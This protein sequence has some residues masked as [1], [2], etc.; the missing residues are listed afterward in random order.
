MQTG[1]RKTLTF[2]SVVKTMWP[3]SSGF[4]C[5]LRDKVWVTLRDFPD[6]AVKRVKDEIQ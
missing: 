5:A 2:F 1:M 3:N 4:R 6:V